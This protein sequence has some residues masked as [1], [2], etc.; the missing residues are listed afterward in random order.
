[1]DVVN[2]FINNKT[3]D[4][5]RDE[6]YDK[7]RGLFNVLVKM[8]RLISEN[9]YNKDK[10]ACIEGI[11]FIKNYIKDNTSHILNSNTSMEFYKYNLE[12]LNDI[13]IK[14][15]NKLRESDYSKESIEDLFGIGI[16]NL[17][18]FLRS[19]FNKDMIVIE[20]DSLGVQKERILKEIGKIIKQIL[21]YLFFINVKVENNVDFEEF[22]DDSVYYAIEC[23]DDNKEDIIIF[24][25]CA[26]KKVLLQIIKSIFRDYEL[27]N[28]D[29]I[30]ISGIEE[31]TK[32][33]SIK[34]INYINNVMSCDYNIIAVAQISCS[35]TYSIIVKKQS[36][37]YI[38]FKTQFGSINY[39]ISFI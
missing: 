14:L 28:L 20:K 24:M 39:S 37:D 26:R 13:F 33:I 25:I 36:E 31:F 16:S 34:C 29:D 4:M 21:E 30:S 27:K 22:T 10:H 9:K 7:N 23:K 32:I 11:K 15:E 2:E 12:R 8:S 17:M 35:D 38:N 18:V 6:F 1:M 5:R 3:I 19:D